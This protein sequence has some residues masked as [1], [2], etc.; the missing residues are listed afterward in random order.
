MTDSSP[1]RNNSWLDNPASTM[2]KA[3]H[4]AIEYSCPAIYQDEKNCFF[5]SKNI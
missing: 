3:V 5:L 2:L 1:A 4:R